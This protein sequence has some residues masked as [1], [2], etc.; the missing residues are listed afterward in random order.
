[1]K[2]DTCMRWNH[3]APQVQDDLSDQR[4]KSEENDLNECSFVAPVSKKSTDDGVVEEA[5]GGEY[6]YPFVVGLGFGRTSTNGSQTRR[7]SLKET[8]NPHL[9]CV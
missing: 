4:D 3:F 7:E 1:M 6:E 5:V 8:P 9:I 2:H